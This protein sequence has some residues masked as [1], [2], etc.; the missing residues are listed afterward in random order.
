MPYSSTAYDL[1]KCQLGLEML[2][3]S[4]EWLFF[5]VFVKLQTPLPTFLFLFF[6]LSIVTSVTAGKHQQGERSRWV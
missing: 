2:S 5:R 6:P 3:L 4:G 1:I